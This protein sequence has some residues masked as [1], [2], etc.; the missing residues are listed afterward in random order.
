ME[1][2]LKTSLAVKI[3][4]FNGINCAELKHLMI[5]VIEV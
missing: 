5:M 2:A 3:W 4:A 1:I